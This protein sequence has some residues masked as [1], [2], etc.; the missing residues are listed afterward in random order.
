MHGDPIGRFYLFPRGK[1]IVKVVS[2]EE[3]S[4]SRSGDLHLME[5]VDLRTGNKHG[6]NFIEEIGAEFYP[7]PEDVPHDE[8]DAYVQASN[9]K[10][11][12][13]EILYDFE[14]SYT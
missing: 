13:E 5:F 11:A 8:I 9:A 3:E 6:A 10:S 14:V 1:T 2:V 4:S 12:A 7:I